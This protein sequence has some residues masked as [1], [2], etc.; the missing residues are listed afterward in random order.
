MEFLSHAIQSAFP[1]ISEHRYWLLFIA[2]VL[3]G[4][5]TIIVAGFLTAAHQFQVIPAVLIMMVGETINSFIWYYAGY[6]GGAR[7]L[8][9][10]VRGKPKQQQMLERIKSYFERYTGQVILIAKLT[11][12]M[13]IVILIFVGT[14]RYDRKKFTFYNIIG[15][16]G[17]VLMIFSLGY[18]FGESY[19]FSV[20]SLRHISYFVLVAVLGVFLLLGAKRLFEDI[21]VRSISVSTAIKKIGDKVKDTFDTGSED[22]K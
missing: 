3:E 14:M 1:W 4:F 21:F 6:W 8:D 15:S 19:Q 11:F 10:F 22:T 2:S 16:I 20:D 12:S 17:W 5:N 13:T 9:F 7:V 18:F